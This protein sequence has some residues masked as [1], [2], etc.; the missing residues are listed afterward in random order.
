MF[1]VTKTVI[2]FY[3]GRLICGLCNK[4]ICRRKSALLC[5][6]CNTWF[7]PKCL[8]NNNYNS[9]KLILCVSC[10]LKNLPFSDNFDDSL[11]KQLFTEE[12][13]TA[14]PNE[15]YNFFNN[16]NS[17]ESPFEFDDHYTPINSKYM[18]I[19]DFN[20]IDA[21]HN[22]SFSIIHLNIA[23]LNRHFD[24]LNNLLS[25]INKTIKLIGIT[26]HKIT[27]GNY[28]HKSL[29]GYNFIFNH[30]RSTHGGA[31]IFIKN[32]LT[33]KIRKDLEIN[34]EN[35]YESTFIEIVFDNEKK[36][37]LWLFI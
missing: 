35:A 9:Q 12:S 24:C 16:C 29:E 5:S 17:L 6:S 23:S 4:R 21:N 30:I 8:K 36:Y 27:E 10:G 32:E 19:K 13:Q 28:L 1:L 11:Q 14:F 20:D 2:L 3:M 25:T 15:V 22:T 18:S 31:G 34:E 7:H 33:Y 26:E 37:Y